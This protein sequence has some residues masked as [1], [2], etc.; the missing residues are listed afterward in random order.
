MGRVKVYISAGGLVCVGSMTKWTSVLK[1]VRVV[2]T[3]E[4]HRW[5]KILSMKMDFSHICL[6]LSLQICSVLWVMLQCSWRLVC[7][8]RIWAFPLEVVQ[9]S[10]EHVSCAWEMGT[11]KWALQRLC[12]IFNRPASCLVVWEEKF[13]GIQVLIASDADSMNQLEVELKEWSQR[14][15]Q[16]DVINRL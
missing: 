11:A 12:G 10:E 7:L 5:K 3:S 6:S 8:S 2:R 13:M 9:T 14:R 4:I 15:E 16:K 1:W